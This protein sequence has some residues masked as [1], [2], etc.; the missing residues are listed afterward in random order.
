MKERNTQKYRAYC[1]TPSPPSQSNSQLIPIQIY[2]HH[3]I[4]FPD[5]P[6]TQTKLLHTSSPPKAK[7]LPIPRQTRCRLEQGVPR[8]QVRPG[9]SFVTGGARWASKAL[10][11]RSVPAGDQPA[12]RGCR[13]RHKVS[14]GV[15]PQGGGGLGQAGRGGAR[16]RGLPAEVGGLE[17]VSN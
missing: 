13:S 1:Q 7:G 6:E 8:G 5:K 16:R 4:P 15:C 11:C 9:Q 12:G 3:P 14:T 2:A 17:K 10:E